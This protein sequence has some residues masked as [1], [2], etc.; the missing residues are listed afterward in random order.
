METLRV[1]LDAMTTPPSLGVV[2]FLV[3]IELLADSPLVAAS[4]LL[5]S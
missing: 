1:S 4:P 3:A 2:S 5:P